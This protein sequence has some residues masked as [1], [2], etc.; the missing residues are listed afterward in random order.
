M[1]QIGSIKSPF[2]TDLTMRAGKIS[3][4]SAPA[5]EFSQELDALRKKD[6]Y[7][8]NPSRPVSSLT[9]GEWKAL[10]EKYDLEHMTDDS[11]AALVDELVA[12]GVFEEGDKKFLEYPTARSK[13]GMRCINDTVGSYIS[14]IGR[15]TTMYLGNANGNAIQWADFRK[16]LELPTDAKGRQKPFGVKSIA[17]FQRLSEVFEKMERA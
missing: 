2:Y 10:A 16:S 13:A 4:A 5:K 14:P 6:T 7:T 1:S 8:S 3:N 15:A 11:Y 12:A 9:Q 17:L